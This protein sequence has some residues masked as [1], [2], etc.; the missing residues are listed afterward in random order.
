MNS[1]T[2]HI[3]L[4]DGHVCS[5]CINELQPPTERDID[6]LVR[7]IMKVP[8]SKSHAKQEIEAYYRQKFEKLR[9]EE[10]EYP[11]LTKLDKKPEHTRWIEVLTPGIYEYRFERANLRD[12]LRSR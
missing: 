11:V 7:D 4:E 1:T 6:E 9:Q 2:D 5:E 10:I 8:Y 3:P 12:K